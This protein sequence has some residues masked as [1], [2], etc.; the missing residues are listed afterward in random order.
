MLAEFAR[1]LHCLAKKSD[2]NV[3]AILRTKSEN[4]KIIEDNIIFFLNN[5]KKGLR[6]SF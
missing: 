1:K 4:L 3:E 6:K 5:L 2:E